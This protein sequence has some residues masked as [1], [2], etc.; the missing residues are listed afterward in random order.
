MDGTPS[1]VLPLL[2]VAGI[3]AGVVLGFIVR[4]TDKPWSNRQIMYIGFP[5]ELL[6]RMMSGVSMP[7]ISS[8]VVAALG[9]SQLPVVGRVGLCAF[10]LSLLCKFLAA[11]GALCVSAFL[12]P[13]NAM[14][15]DT[16]ASNSTS[17]LRL[18]VVAT[19]RLLD[20]I[21][22]QTVP[23]LIIALEEGLQMDPRLARFLGPL[24][25]VVNMDGT[26]IYLIIALIFCAQKNATGLSA[27][28]YITI[29]SRISNALNVLGDAVVASGT[30][31]LCRTALDAAKSPDAAA[32]AAPPVEDVDGPP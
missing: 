16:A 13:G 8:S 26:T 1:R 14:H 22:S 6:Q 3:A 12:A 10:L 30:Q 32:E 28:Q 23:A 21:S 2:M 4:F 20:L 18:S 5:G 7:L 25:S 29:G 31:G 11:S 19:D 24:G 15:V 27:L 17:N 9:S